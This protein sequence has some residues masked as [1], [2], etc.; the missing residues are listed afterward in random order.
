M[1][2]QTHRAVGVVGVAF[3]DDAWFGDVTE[4]LILMFICRRTRFEIDYVAANS[5]RRKAQI[6]YATFCDKGKRS[7]WSHF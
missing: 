3:V 4:T 6:R 5:I 2:G 7:V 1:I